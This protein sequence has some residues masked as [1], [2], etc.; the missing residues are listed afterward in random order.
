MKS[1]KKKILLDKE[2]KNPM[3]SPQKFLKI[4]GKEIKN[5]EIYNAWMKGKP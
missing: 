4:N 3:L 5:Y 1:S 2:I